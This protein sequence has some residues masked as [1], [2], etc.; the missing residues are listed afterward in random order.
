M[1]LVLFSQ[2]TPYFVFALALVLRLREYLHNRSLWLDEAHV[3][4]KVLA[5]SFWDDI[6][7][8][9]WYQ[10][11]PVGIAVLTRVLV[12]V[13]GDSEYVLR[14]LP[15]LCGLLSFPLL[16][17]FS[18]EYLKPQLVPLA[19]LLFSVAPPLVYYSS[20]V[21]QYS[22]DVFICLSLL[23]LAADAMRS[24][25]KTRVW[26][27]GLLA[28]LL[29]WF[30]FPA[31]FV[32]LGI[33][34]AFAAQ[35][36]SGERL[37]KIAKAVPWAVFWGLSL[38]LHY[39]TFLRYISTNSKLVQQWEGWG[40]FGPSSGSLVVWARWLVTAL[41][42]FPATI[43]ISFGRFAAALALFGAFV[44]LRSYRP[45]SYL[46]LAPAAFL[47]TAAAAGYYP[48]LLRVVL[49]AAPLFLIALLKGLEAAGCTRFTKVL[50]WG[51]AIILS[52]Q[53]VV[54]AAQNFLHPS[55][56]EHIRP[57]LGHLKKE[58]KRGD[59]VYISQFA[60]DAFEYSLRREPLPAPTFVGQCRGVPTEVCEK[61]FLG[62]V[63]GAEYLWV[64]L[65]HVTPE[66]RYLL[67][68]I[69]DKWGE[70]LSE[71]ESGNALLLYYHRKEREH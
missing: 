2:K 44:L 37:K 53:V 17:R 19:L 48:V 25:F 55:V 34:M 63:E 22:S 7:S 64:F 35:I 6:L 28:S 43:G 46:I 32:C 23:V 16:F 71:L 26:P 4:L 49:F 27:L 54:G 13:F 5:P 14:L 24:N 38:G 56:R 30:S 58:L 11:L 21:K 15:L 52:G 12:A 39:F 69:A 33:A 10:T 18:R 62:R 31:V 3:A 66:E 51:A 41:T 60:S 20:E 8:G 29:T 67:V 45:K 59:A 57:L 70:R 61:D 47:V 50:A 36:P 40:G 42:T 9:N 65:S 68:R 1:T